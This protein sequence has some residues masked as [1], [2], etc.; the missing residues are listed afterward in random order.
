MPVVQPQ[1]QHLGIKGAQLAQLN[2]LGVQAQGIPGV[3]IMINPGISFGSAIST[4]MPI[5]TSTT[6]NSL[7]V[8]AFSLLLYVA[9]L[10]II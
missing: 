7:R 5:I 9:F 4:S 2:I 3:Q 1:L 6:I 10:L 8:N